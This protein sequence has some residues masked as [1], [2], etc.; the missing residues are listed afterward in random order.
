MTNSELLLHGLGYLLAYAIPVSIVV[1][2]SFYLLDVVTRG[3]HLGSRL[4]GHGVGEPSYSAGVVTT[5]WILAQ[6]WIMHTAIM[7]NGDSALGW[8]LGTTLVFSLVGA[9]LLAAVFVGVDKLT[10]GD[11]SEMVCQPGRAVPMAYVTGGFLIT[12]AAVISASMTG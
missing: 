2:V 4:T 6:G 11:L 3:S 7:Q 12:V 9:L 8:A 10:P 5:A 1:V